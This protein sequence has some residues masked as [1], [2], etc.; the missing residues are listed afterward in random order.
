[1]T[2]GYELLVTG[3]SPTNPDSAVDLDNDGVPE[4]FLDY[5]DNLI[6]DSEDDFDADGLPNQLEYYVRTNPHSSDSDHDESVIV[7]KTITKTTTKTEY[8]IM[9]NIMFS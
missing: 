6:R 3:T 1:M 8:W 4:S 9:M 2:D 5:S 7:T